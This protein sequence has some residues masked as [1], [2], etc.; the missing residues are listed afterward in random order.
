MDFLGHVLSWEQVKPN[1]KKAR[2]IREWPRTTTVQGVRSFGKLLQGCGLMY[3]ATNP[4]WSAG[5]FREATLLSYAMALKKNV[6]DFRSSRF[7]VLPRQV[8][9]GRPWHLMR[10]VLQII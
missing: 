9:I 8:I 1:P 3:S 6:I 5:W 7:V 10:T 2:A 4:R